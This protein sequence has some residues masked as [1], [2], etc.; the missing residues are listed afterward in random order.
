[1]KEPWGLTSAA[2]GRVAM[3]RAR[4][5]RSGTRLWILASILS[6]LQLTIPVGMFNLFLASE[7]TSSL[8]SG[9]YETR[10][11]LKAFAGYIALGL[12]VIITGGA[13]KAAIETTKAEPRKPV[14]LAGLLLATYLLAAFLWFAVGDPLRELPPVAQ[15]VVVFYFGLYLLFSGWMVKPVWDLLTDGVR[16]AMLSRSS[17][18]D[19]PNDQL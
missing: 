19:Q 3:W 15:T 9:T 17:A 6:V 1:M 4:L 5:A 2:R 10:V 16:D 12:G 14:V 8:T 7:Q 18:A 11:I 13:M